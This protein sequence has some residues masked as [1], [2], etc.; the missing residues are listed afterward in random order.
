MVPKLK[1]GNFFPYLI[2]I[3]EGYDHSAISREINAEAKN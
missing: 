2:T 1:Y 3:P